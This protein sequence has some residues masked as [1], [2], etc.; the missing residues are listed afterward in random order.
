[1]QLGEA[2]NGDKEFNQSHQR[3]ISQDSVKIDNKN[4]PRKSVVS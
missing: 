1:M 3:N 4:L 2:I